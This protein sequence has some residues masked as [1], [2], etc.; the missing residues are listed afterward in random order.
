MAS[1]MIHLRVAQQ[2]YQQL[3]I[4]PTDKFIL[5]N[6]APDS[7]IPSEDSDGFVPD[8]AVSHFRSLDNNGIKNI[9]EELFIEQ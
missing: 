8:A 2:I 5:G 3:N 9:H 7:G 1:W 6:I 4:E